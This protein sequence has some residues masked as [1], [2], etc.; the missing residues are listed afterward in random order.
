M[1][2]PNDGA[3]TPI[4]EAPAAAAATVPRKRKVVTE[5]EKHFHW[6]ENLRNEE[7][8]MKE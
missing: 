3:R 8:T 1:A 4:V 6:L 2:T 5:L 7:R